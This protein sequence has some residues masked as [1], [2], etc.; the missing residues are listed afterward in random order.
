M[1]IA[2]WDMATGHRERL[3][4]Y[5]SPDD[6]FVDVPPA[7]TQPADLDVLIASRY[8]AADRDRARYR[9]MQVPGAG[10]DKIDF[11]IVRPEATVCNAYEHEQPIAEYVFAAILDFTVGYGALTRR[12]PELGWAG[13]YLSRAPHGEAAGRT[14]GLI[15]LG[16]IGKA[17]ARRAKAFDM[18]VMAVTG[19]RHNAA[20]D[21]DWL[22]TSDRL[23]EMLERADFVVVAC[24][25]N[26]ATRGMLG[27]AEFKRMKPTAVLINVARAEIA[28]EQDLYE[29]LSTGVIGG[30]VLDAWYQ[31]PQSK[32]DPVEPSRFPLA[33]LDNVR[34]T[35]HSSAWTDG[36][37]E[38]RCRLFGENIRRL[39]AGEPLL[40][41]VRAPLRP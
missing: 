4:Q 7:P 30:A 17:I 1:R 20:D 14:V 16:H 21:V 34:V 23:H 26:D 19:T 39:K 8:V 9:L 5:L 25:L 29:A 40:N 11:A 18:T 27:K 6:E 32:D 31:Y 3:R 24:P 36:V 41:V 22:A 15:G 13:A 33:A 12:I 28:R 38:R 37:W 2:L 35:A 10:L